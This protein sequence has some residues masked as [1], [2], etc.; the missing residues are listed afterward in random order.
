V[1]AN[2]DGLVSIQPCRADL[3]AHDALDALTTALAG[4]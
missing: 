4:G 1:E 3:T 2:L